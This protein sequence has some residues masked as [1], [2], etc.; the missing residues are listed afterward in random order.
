MGRCVDS[1][2]RKWGTLAFALFTALSSL[3]TLLSL[4]GGL[5]SLGVWAGRV[6]GGL[7]TSLLFCAPEGW[8]V[9][10]VRRL[11]G[12]VEA[13]KAP[14][15]SS[16]SSY[17]PQLFGLAYAGDSVVAI[18]AGMLAG[19]GA[20]G[21]AKALGVMPGPTAPFMLSVGVL[22][23][24]SVL[25]A[26]LWRENTASPVKSDG[27]T[28]S[29]AKATISSAVRLIFTNP[30]ILLLGAVQ[31]LF[32]GAMYIFVLQW[33]PAM[34]KAIEGWVGSSSGA[35][36]PY[37]GIFSCFMACCLLGSTIFS[38]VNTQQKQPGWNDAE[39]SSDLSGKK[40]SRVSLSSLLPR[41]AESF[42]FGLLLLSALSL[43]TAGG[44]MGGML[45]LSLSPASTLG[46]L[47]MSLF[48][49]EMCVGGYFPAIGTLRARYLPDSHRSTLITLFG[50]PLYSLVISVSYN[51][52]RMGGVSG[53]LLCAGAALS[54]A[55][56]CM[57]GLLRWKNRKEG[58]NKG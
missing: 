48:L 23:L 34:R 36:V 55:G 22:S 2:G 54:V 4:D 26:G 24:A 52:H 18:L 30:Q 41:S 40:K 12:E 47:T 51:I 35:V 46:V 42:M 5:R 14:S 45:P 56:G 3:S 8:L 53:A 29:P 31:A 16:P 7:G 20:G 58:E 43:L 13:E 1:I 11:D 33:P 27:V 21:G 15:T 6:A 49:F 25:V 37:G 19:W 38:G 28:S 9:G 39:N 32:E 17:L 44:L 50:L 57:A 10:E